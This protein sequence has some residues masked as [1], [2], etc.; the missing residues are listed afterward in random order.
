MWQDIVVYAIG[1]V[2]PIYLLYRIVRWLRKSKDAP[3]GCCGCSSCPAV[4]K[5]PKAKP[6]GS[7]QAG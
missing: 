6:R 2:I 4:K 7:G 3:S 5:G 1:M